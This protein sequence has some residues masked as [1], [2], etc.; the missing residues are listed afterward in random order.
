MCYF[1][2]GGG[3]H[4]SSFGW[5]SARAPGADHRRRTC[6]VCKDHVHLRDN[7]RV[8]AWQHL[9]WRQSRQPSRAAAAPAMAAV[10]PPVVAYLEWESLHVPG[11]PATSP[12]APNTSAPRGIDCF[13]RTTTASSAC[14]ASPFTRKTRL[15]P[16]LVDVRAHD[17]PVKIVNEPAPTTRLRSDGRAGAGRALGQG[18]ALLA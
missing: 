2:G 17:A 18:G 14:P 16:S 10:A 8:C 11:A 5:A 13:S 9:P 15:L 12:T 7:R 4:V 6:T 3:H 1:L